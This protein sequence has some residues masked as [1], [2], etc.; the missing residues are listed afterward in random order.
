M[1]LFCV[2]LSII[3]HKGFFALSSEVLRHDSCQRQQKQHCCKKGFNAW[4]QHFLVSVGKQKF[5]ATVGNCGRCLKHNFYPLSKG[6]TYAFYWEGLGLFSSI[7]VFSRNTGPEL[8]IWVSWVHS[9]VGD[10][11]LW[12]G[13]RAFKLQ[14]L[15]PDYFRT[16]SALF[17]KRRD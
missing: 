3:V 16:I 2:N 4:K 12:F 14:H 8:S 6:S 10:E 11:G 9:G 13:G 1:F 7:S 17:D 15:D 5:P